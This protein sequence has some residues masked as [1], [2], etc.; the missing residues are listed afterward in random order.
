MT[1][2]AEKR[3]FGRTCHFNDST[4]TARVVA[5]AGTDPIPATVDNIGPGGVCLRTLLPLPT[6]RPLKLLLEI[7]SQPLFVTIIRTSTLQNAWQYGAKF[8]SYVNH[9]RVKIGIVDHAILCK[10]RMLS[11]PSPPSNLWANLIHWLD[12][13]FQ[14][15]VRLSV[16]VVF[17]A[18]AVFLLL[19]LW[20]QL[21]R[22]LPDSDNALI[23]TT[24][25]W[26]EKLFALSLFIMLNLRDF[27]N[28][29]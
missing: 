4:V 16:H 1:L 13:S 6:D 20:S 12:H 11:D 29:R 24:F 3:Q 21:E 22:Y 23:E 14:N 19:W 25:M 28:N 18:L 9:T 2:T 10:A 27:Y 26:A 17:N 8:D 15:F 7:E 5:F